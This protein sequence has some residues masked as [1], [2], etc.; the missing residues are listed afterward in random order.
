MLATSPAGSRNAPRPLGVGLL[1]APLTSVPWSSRMNTSSFRW[2]QK[3]LSLVAGGRVGEVSCLLETWG[4]FSWGGCPSFDFGNL[5]PWGGLRLLVKDEGTV[6]QYRL[7]G[8][9][10]A[11]WIPYL[12]CFLIILKGSLNDW[13]LSWG[14]RLLTVKCLMRVKFNLSKCLV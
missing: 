8:T 11:H 5:A 13:D 7:Q 1:L 12:S 4:W 6:G 3:V 9:V 2:V 10:L 14:L